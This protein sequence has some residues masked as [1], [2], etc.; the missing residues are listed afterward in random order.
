MGVNGD[1]KRTKIR[2]RW[3]GELKNNVNNGLFEVKH[4]IGLLGYKDRYDIKH[5]IKN[6]DNILNSLLN[7][8][9]NDLADITF[10]SISPLKSV[11]INRYHR[12]YYESPDHKIR[13]TLDSDLTFYSI[14]SSVLNKINYVMPNHSIMEVKYDQ[15]Y[16]SLAFNFIGEMPFRLSKCSKYELGLRNIYG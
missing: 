1:C 7:C 9:F 16:D 3:Y 14:Y 13:I 6:S 4:K 11:L 10:K 12:K 8:E 2:F 5:K 15:G